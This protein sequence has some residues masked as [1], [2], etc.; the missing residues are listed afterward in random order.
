MT[1]SPSPSVAATEIWVFAPVTGDGIL[2]LI[3]AM[4]AAAV[5]VVGYSFQKTQARKTNQAVIYGEAIRAVHDYLEAPYRVARRD[6]SASARMAITSHVSD[7]QSRIAYFETLLRVEAPQN[8]SAAFRQLVA[9]VRAEAGPQ[10]T[11]AWRKR[12]TRRD[13]EVPLG[14]RLQQPRSQ[15]LLEETIVLMG[16]FGPP[17]RPRP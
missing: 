14:S 4:L 12:P 2:S 1:P 17:P 15:A 5:V 11:E 13:S 7:I 3:A 9:A 8:V 6:G 16:K 10:I